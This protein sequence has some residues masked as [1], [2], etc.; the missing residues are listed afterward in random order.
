MKKGNISIFIPH[1]G[2]PQQCSFCNQ[3]TI[4]GNVKQPTADDVR[5]AVEIALKKKG[6]EY[7]IAF[8]GGSFTAI[9]RDYMLTLLKSAYPYVEDGRVN[10]IRISTRPDFIDDEVLTLLKKYGV[11][12]IELGAQSMDDEV[13]KANLRGHTAQD[14]VN[15]SNLIK[16][17]G[18]ELGLQMMTGLYLDTDKKAIETAKKI[19]A[20]QPATVRI[21][22]TVVLKGTMLAKLYEDEVFNPQT[23]DD[24]ANLCTKLVPMFEE[25]GIKIIRLGLHASNDIKKNAVAGAYHESFG[26]IVKSRFMLN[27]ILK[28]RPGDYEIMVNP[29][30]VSQLKGQ[31]KRNIYFLMEEG[32]N[33][34][35]TVTDKVAKDDLKI[36]RR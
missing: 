16:S 29:R 7:E 5:E 25:A 10:G 28:L 1:L 21:Y 23:V 4:T 34:K 15:A 19:I 11:T 30:S 31:Q 22:P 35:V 20:L 18:F 24:A 2:C 27:K 14:V 26:E 17:Y 6:Y 9:D 33:I 12:S 13:L 36:I 3:K 32:Y 8:F